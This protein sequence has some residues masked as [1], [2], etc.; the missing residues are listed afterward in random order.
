MQQPKFIPTLE[1]WQNLDLRGELNLAAV[2]KMETRVP[3]QFYE[4]R[5]ANQSTSTLKPKAYFRP[6]TSAS[7]LNEKE[8]PTLCRIGTA[9]FTDPEELKRTTGINVSRYMNFECGGCVRFAGT[10]SVEF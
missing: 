7:W 4:L 3:Y 1:G 8:A 2:A 6:F 5:D 10:L 9:V